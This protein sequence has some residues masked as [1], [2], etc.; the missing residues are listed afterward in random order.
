VP[1]A[2]AAA[3]ARERRH[4]C[5][6]FCARQRFFSEFC[7]G[8]DIDQSRFGLRYRFAGG[9]LWDVIDWIVD[10]T[11]VCRRTSRHTWLI[12]GFCWTERTS[13]TDG[14]AGTRGRPRGV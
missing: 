14:S 2:E 7:E 5:D 6:R 12:A 11:S 3:V 8:L 9:A 4:F 10:P 13:S 1:C